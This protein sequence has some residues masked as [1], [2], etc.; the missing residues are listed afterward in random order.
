MELKDE[1][2]DL[3]DELELN[4]TKCRAPTTPYEE[5]EHTC[6]GSGDQASLIIPKKYQ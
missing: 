6:V 3:N 1:S 2:V 4:G 5:F